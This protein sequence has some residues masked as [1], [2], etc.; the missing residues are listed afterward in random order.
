MSNITIHEVKTKNDLKT[1]IHLP[2][3]IH[4]GHKEWL[5]PLISDE[6]KVFDCNKNH[7]LEQCDTVLYLAKKDG[8]VEGRIMGIIN[9]KYNEANGENNG[10]FCF[11]ECYDD[12]EVFDALINSTENWAKQKGMTNLVGPLG[13]S[14]KDPQGFLVKGFNDPMTVIVTNCSYKYMIKHMERTGYLKKLD[15]VQY[16]MNIPKSSPEIYN[17]IAKRNT[18]KGYNILE[19]TKTKHVRKYIKP[20]FDLIN[21]TYRNI[22]GFAALTDIEATEF[23]ERF[24]PLLNPSFIKIILSPEQD[25][26]AFVVAMPD[27]S[28]GMRKAK[29]RLYPIG[30]IPIL[31]SMKKTK[32]LNLLLGCVKES[33]RNTGL[34]SLLAVKIFE[35]AKE[36]GLEI[37]DSHLIME[38]NTKMRAEIER[39]HGEVYKKYRIFEKRLN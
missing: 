13:F 32:Q 33:F 9:H 36:E 16:R 1:F 23:S 35:S 27:I 2:Y 6:W 11:M 17:K 29:G 30:F 8:K 26:V 20:V 25:I 15:L 12:A 19:F 10:R 3:K 7:S 14:D 4:K 39:L 24:L 34:D 38:T 5:P 22:Y 18:D 21:E 28:E 37:I 31:R